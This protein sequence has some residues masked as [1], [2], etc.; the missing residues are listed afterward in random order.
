MGRCLIVE[1]YPGWV[2]IYQEILAFSGC[3][4]EVADNLE[5]AVSMVK[6]KF[7]LYICDGDFPLNVNEPCAYSGAFFDFYEKLVGVFPNPNLLLV[8]ASNG[9]VESARKMGIYSLDKN[10]NFQILKTQILDAL[11]VS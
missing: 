11:K 7:D 8:S 9:N 1:D 10:V 3:S 5:D 2:K 6:K 4:I